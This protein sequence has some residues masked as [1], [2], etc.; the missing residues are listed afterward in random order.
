MTKLDDLDDDATTAPTRAEMDA[1]IATMD[2]EPVVHAAAGR[3]ANNLDTQLT[4][5]DIDRLAIVPDWQNTAPPSDVR[6]ARER[7]ETAVTAVQEAIRDV[8]AITHDRHSEAC[9]AEAAISSALDAGKVA[10]A[11]KGTDWEAVTTFRRQVQRVAGQRLVKARSD[12]DQAVVGAL[13]EWRKMLRKSVITERNHALQVVAPAAQAFGRWRS[14]CDAV[15]AIEAVADP[16]NFRRLRILDHEAARVRS[17]GIGGMSRAVALLAS[18]HPV[19][20]GDWASR[21]H[22]VQPADYVRRWA[23]GTRHDTE[24]WLACTEFRERYAVTSYCR[25]LETQVLVAGGDKADPGD[26]WASDPRLSA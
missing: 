21:V 15:D 4:R 16:D 14:A 25:Q 10:K 18:D 3:G 1:L 20:V 5:Y 23:A 6:A 26:P 24:W 17:E 8:D 13:P 19:H 2:G 11:T 12:Y 7:L 22:D 9:D